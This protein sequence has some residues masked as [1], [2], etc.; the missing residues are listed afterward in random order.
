METLIQ[1]IEARE[2]EKA[3]RQA[4]FKKHN[5]VKLK[6]KEDLSKQGSD[7]KLYNLILFVEEQE[8]DEVVVI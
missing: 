6:V 3:S 1:E 8:G 5:I 2:K 4:F 7:S